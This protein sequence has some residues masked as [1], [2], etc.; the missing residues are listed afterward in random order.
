LVLAQRETNRDL[1]KKYY[2]QIQ[3]MVALELPYVSLWYE[4]NV[5]FMRE[6]VEG[7]ELWPNASFMGLVN[8]IKESPEQKSVNR[9]GI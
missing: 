6:D 1:R 9:D 4:D 2:S 3:K 7:Y 5:V 8:V